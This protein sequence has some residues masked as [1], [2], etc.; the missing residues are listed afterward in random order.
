MRQHRGGAGPGPAA[1]GCV[2]R[3]LPAYLAERELARQH[4]RDAYQEFSEQRAELRQRARTQRGWTEK[5]LRREARRP[6]DPDKIGTRSICRSTSAT[7]IAITGPNGSGKSTL[8]ALLL[9]H[10][11]PDA[12]TVSI[13]ASVSVGEVDQA[14][15]LS[16]QTTTLLEVFAGRLPERAPAEIRTLLAKFGLAAEHVARPTISRSP[17]ERTRATLALLQATGVNLLVLD[18][19]TNHLDLPAIEQLEQARDDYARCC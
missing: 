3:R 1:G 15:G 5:G 18:E 6:R 19:P 9:G 2:R 14:R 10:L 16:S 7:G 17:G 8:L 12:G 11:Q 4:A 13:G